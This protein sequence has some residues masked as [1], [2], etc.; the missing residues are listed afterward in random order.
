MF[1]RDWTSTCLG[2]L[3]HPDVKAVSS[4]GGAVLKSNEIWLVN[5]ELELVEKVGE[6]KAHSVEVCD[7]RIVV[8]GSTLAV[9]GK[10]PLGDLRP[11]GG[12]CWCGELFVAEQDRV[13][14]TDL[15]KILLALPVPDPLDV[16]CHVTSSLMPPLWFLGSVDSAIEVL[17]EVGDWRVRRR[18]ESDDNLVLSYLTKSS[19]LRAD[20]DEVLIEE[21]PT[22][23][24]ASLETGE[25]FEATLSRLLRV[26]VRELQLKPLDKKTASFSTVVAVAT[27]S[28]GVYIFY[29]RPGSLF[30]DPTSA[31]AGRRPLNGARSVALSQTTGDLAVALA[32]G[33]I[34]IL[35]APSYTRTAHVVPVPAS[36]VR[37]WPSSNRLLAILGGGTLA[38]L[39]APPEPKAGL[40]SQW[41]D[42]VVAGLFEH[43]GY[44]GARPLASTCG[45]LRQVFLRL[46]ITWRLA[47]LDQ[48]GFL[49]AHHLFDKWGQHLHNTSEPPRR[50]RGPFFATAEAAEVARLKAILYKDDGTSATPSAY[51]VHSTT[52]KDDDDE[53]IDEEVK[54]FLEFGRGALC[55][56]TGEYG[57]KL[58][59]HRRRA[60]AEDF[61]DLGTEVVFTQRI[62]TA[63]RGDPR[64]L[65]SCRPET[66]TAVDR[67][68]FLEFWTHLRE[69]VLG[70]RPWPMGTSLKG[71]AL[72]AAATTDRPIKAREAET[73]S[74]VSGNTDIIQRRRLDSHLSSMSYFL[75]QHARAVD[76]LVLHSA[77]EDPAGDD[78]LAL[79]R[80]QAGPPWWARMTPEGLHSAAAAA[81]QPVTI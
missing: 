18:A 59:W 41:P 33:G 66:V 65:R 9:L 34:A 8:A 5:D 40:L 32:E 43:L 70:F 31:F 21:R 62:D 67:G 6:S 42:F 1:G 78:P 17:S 39:T 20:V 3:V 76:R 57:A 29:Y 61:V 24:A 56:V 7:E 72:L 58:W 71:T 22:G 35:T 14:V 30:D 52:T 44:I 54:K 74:L 60:L 81:V 25:F 19:W 12:L 50:P 2:R 11:R 77:E 36:L 69:Y 37:F 63:T 64:R 4:C 80:R 28:Q 73:L 48:K 75:D 16:A 55:A 15:E 68:A 26:L 27:A 53:T 10:N 47:P 23:F 38:T 79:H 51:A 46:R 13:L 45:A 49:E